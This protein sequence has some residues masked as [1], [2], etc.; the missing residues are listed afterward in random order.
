MGGLV[1]AQYRDIALGS[2]DEKIS[3]FIGWRMGSQM[4]LF[5]NIIHIN[6]SQR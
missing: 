5:N 3:R 1:D 6:S 4:I 2:D